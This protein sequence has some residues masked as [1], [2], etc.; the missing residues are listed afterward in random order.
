M[1]GDHPH[2][3]IWCNER[4]NVGEPPSLLYEILAK[5]EAWYGLKPYLENRLKLLTNAFGFDYRSN[6]CLTLL[7]FEDIYRVRLLADRYLV[8]VSTE[9]VDVSKESQQFF[10]ADIR[11]LELPKDPLKLKGH[12]LKLSLLIRGSWSEIIRGISIDVKVK[13]AR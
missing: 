11:K 5:N 12:G 10:W 8:I 13:Q 6:L 4:Q 3:P 7:T 2:W 1:A 9:H